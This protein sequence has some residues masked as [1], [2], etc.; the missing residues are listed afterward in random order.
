MKKAAEEAAVIRGR[1][2][3]PVPS[4]DHGEPDPS[5]FSS[6]TFGDLE[7]FRKSFQSLEKDVVQ[8]QQEKSTE[9]QSLKEI[10][11]N[12]VKSTFVCF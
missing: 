10:E 2:I 9:L 11:S 1:L 12:Q 3:N 8:L 7:A 6:W 4:T 5:E